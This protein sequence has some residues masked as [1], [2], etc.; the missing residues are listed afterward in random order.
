MKNN[1]I[2]DKDLFFCYTKKL[3][4]Y[5]K[6]RGFS[7]I[8]KAKSIKDDSVFTLYQMTPDLQQAVEQFTKIT[9]QENQ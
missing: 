7:Y 4:I 2:T 3:S 9:K 1:Q 5:L 6:N 8:F